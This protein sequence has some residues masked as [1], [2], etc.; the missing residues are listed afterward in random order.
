MSKQVV[1]TNPNNYVQSSSQCTFFI[2]PRLMLR[3]VDHDVRKFRARWALQNLGITRCSDI[4]V[5]RPRWDTSVNPSPPPFCTLYL[6]FPSDSDVLV[7]AAHLHDQW[8]VGLSKPGN[9]K[10]VLHAFRLVHSIF[11]LVL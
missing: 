7:A 9:S 4:Q 5:T 3:N 11:K 6:T 8:V 2:M 10:R 1:H